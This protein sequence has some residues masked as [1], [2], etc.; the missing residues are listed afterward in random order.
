MTQ[1]GFTAIL[2]FLVAILIISV[3]IVSGS[4]FIKNKYL[5]KNSTFNQTIN[6]IKNSVIQK[7]A[8]QI[9]AYLERKGKESTASGLVDDTFSLYD[10]DKQEPIAPDPVIFSNC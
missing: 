4:L 1:K 2:I 10:L 7:S 3:L 9:L 6:S 5:N 8:P